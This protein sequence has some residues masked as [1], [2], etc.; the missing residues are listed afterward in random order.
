VSRTNAN[1]SPLSHGRRALRRYQ[2]G[3]VVLATC[4]LVAGVG[5][6]PQG[7]ELL[8]IHVRNHD[9]A[10]ARQVL[11][12]GAEYGVSSTASVVAHGELYL[13]EGRVDESLSEMEVYVEQH[14]TDAGAWQHL[15]QLY[16][17]AQRLQDEIQALTNLYRL[18]P[19]ESLARRLIALYRGNGDEPAEASLLQDLVD[20]GSATADEHVRAAQLQAA[21]GRRE[22]AFE[23]LEQL[24]RREPRA[25]DYAALEMYASLLIDLGRTSLL[26]Q[27]IQTL[28]IAREQPGVLASLGGAM[29]GWGRMDA[30]MALF[31]PLPGAEPSPQL[32]AGRARTARDT[33]Q[34]A[35]VVA[36]MAALDATRPLRPEP[37][38]AFVDLALT[39][40]DYSA[41]E[42]VL[43]NP[44]R[45]P[46]PD[47]VAA[48]IGYAVSHDARHQAQALITHLGDDSLSDSPWL[49]L[50]LAV[51][52]GDT[53]SAERWIA[54]V[55]TSGKATAEQ[56]AALAQFE[57]KAGFPERA[58]DRLYR[59]VDTGNPPDWALTDLATLAGRL[60]R[61][62]ESL[63][64]LGPLS[65]HSAAAR[66]V[67]ARL[68]ATAGRSDL[69]GAWFDAGPPS[70]ADAQTLRDVYFLL[71][72]RKDARLAL[73]AARRLH[74]ASGTSDDALLLGQAL[75]AEG[76][77]VEALEPLRQVHR[78]SADAALAYDTALY[79]ALVDG[80]AVDTE[81]RAVFGSRLLDDSVD[82]THRG[83]L[84]EALWTIGER[85][86]LVEPIVALAQQDVGRWLSPLVE[87]ARASGELDRAIGVVAEALDPAGGETLGTDGAAHP[88][89]DEPLVHALMDLGAPETI[90]LPHLE[91]L[92]HD[93]GGTW[94]YAY[95]EH[96]ARVGRT[97]EQVT[98]W[99]TIGL[100]DESSDETRRAAASRLVELDEPARAADVTQRL[101]AAAGP[102]DPDLE[103]LLS[104]WGPHPSGEQLEWLAVRLEQAPPSDQPAWMSHL[105]NAAGSAVVART[106]PDLPEHASEAFV[107]AWVD[108][109]RATGDRH[110]LQQAL[111]RVLAR[112]NSSAS[113]L[114][115]AGRAALAENLTDLAGR[116][117]REVVS[118]DPLDLE[119]TR[120][121]G[122]LAFYDGRR[123]ESRNWL[124]AYEAAGGDE[125][126][127]LYQLGEIARADRE[128]D[129]ARERFAQALD[130]LTDPTVAAANQTLLANVL[131]RLDDRDRA[132]EIFERLLRDDAALDHVRAD[133]V[134]A[135]LQWGDYER[136]RL[137]L[138]ID[139]N[140]SQMQMATDPGGAR[141]LDLL[142]VQWYVFRGRYADAL[143]VLDDLAARFPSD[144]DVL[145]AQG[146]FDAERGRLA[147]AD[148]RYDAA[149]AEAPQREDISDLLD[150]LERQRSPRA[151]VETEHRSVSDAWDEGSTK[152]LVE[153]RLRSHTP[154]SVKVQ[155]LHIT[156]PS[157]LRSDGDSTR[158]DA[159]L[160]QF[161]VSATVPVAIGT[162]ATGAV[163]GTS[164]GPGAGLTLTRH[165]LRGVS[166]VTAELGRPVWDLL[167]SAADDGRRD[168]LSTQ[169]EWRLGAE[170]SAWSVLGW[171]RY[172]LASGASLSSTALGLGVVRTVRHHSPTLAVQYGLDKEHVRSATV[173]TAADRRPFVPIPLSSREV[174]VFGAISRFTALNLWETE[175]AAGYTIDRLGGRGSFVT[176]RAIPRPT[177]RVG[178]ELW[179][180]RQLYTIAT[181][182]Q[183][184]RSG[185]RLTTR[186]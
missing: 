19:S 69:L 167:E 91:R 35:L 17:N 9:V 178:V 144:P 45:A 12:A 83:L 174:H 74:A 48:V 85:A 125:P 49:A 46:D 32:L 97:P 22:T 119:A 128:N 11:A 66:G 13:F 71:S 184:F 15:A 54:R 31:E 150:E 126:E 163:F 98:L 34:A 64:V 10:Q 89:V 50:E 75:L 130:R 61:V 33:D 148:R 147:Q 142:R 84:V 21:F 149:R 117:F 181:T 79:G 116:A 8:L 87:S 146:Q 40:S 120:W 153:G 183:V 112:N 141:R 159:D 51:D 161:E 4:A 129:R 81:L 185:V 77:P 95:D 20:R 172:R 104:L 25:F 86:S 23:S 170:M 140:A 60:G 122:T 137:V 118:L 65:R 131:V 38:H 24:R 58:F 92:A 47:V 136:A 39:I 168:R 176:A 145:L 2:L 96:L 100:A 42:R 94:V 134:V 56:V 101:A 133:Y 127:P 106:F 165:D 37:L 68:A 124:T 143:K 186:F 78:E 70:E 62:N 107:G 57:I 3:A 113:V 73:R 160:S 156:A 171:N 155:R 110:L 99:T 1:A 111:E 63:D 41:I 115:Q 109:H 67:W 82:P 180:E 162:T 80:A 182:H 103:Q 179:A 121:L 158:L 52:R 164:G 30:A 102:A 105:I 169:R 108:A 28:P 18:A 76:R 6:L 173:V 88:Q 59:F 93:A 135:L 26:A 43:T 138:Q 123:R 152:V 132:Q 7:D 27:R 36:E 90:L 139:D 175:V 114:R 29:R 166:S 14:P 157:V 154:V 177:A 44:A 53:A 72:D 16:G 55:D 151:S 5:L